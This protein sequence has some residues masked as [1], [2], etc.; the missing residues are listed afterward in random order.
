M[1]QKIFFKLEEEENTALLLHLLK[2]FVKT[3]VLVS[4]LG[5]DCRLVVA[6][7]QV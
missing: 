2:V 7:V 1:D 3:T 5:T 4:A 6:I